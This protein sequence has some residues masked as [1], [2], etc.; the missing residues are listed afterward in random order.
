M[1]QDATHVWEKNDL[2]KH[3]NIWKPET[4][5]RK[6]GVEEHIKKRKAGQA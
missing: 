6:K 5:V 1:A 4:D 2:L 3:Q